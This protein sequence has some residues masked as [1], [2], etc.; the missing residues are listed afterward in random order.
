MLPSLCTLLLELLPNLLHH[1]SQALFPTAPHPGHLHFLGASYMWIPVVWT[2][3]TNSGDHP[4][5]SCPSY[6][7]CWLIA[8]PY[9]H[10]AQGY[11]GPRKLLKHPPGL[12]K[13][14]TLLSTQQIVLLPLLPLLL[15]ALASHG[16][17]CLGNSH[18][19][20][21]KWSSK[22]KSNTKR[23]YTEG[24]IRDR[25]LGTKILSAHISRKLWR[26]SSAHPSP[27]PPAQFEGSRRISALVLYFF[28]Q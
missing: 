26:L 16:S 13:H 2:G 28:G 22:L 12:H 6:E 21:S 5:L 23:K 20:S 19:H 4:T 25:L 17:N 10:R 3:C 9:T 24:G 8:S 18:H 11:W 27:T 1:S 7:T 14:H 15:L